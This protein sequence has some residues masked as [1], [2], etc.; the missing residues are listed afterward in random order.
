[1]VGFC[2]FQ[3]LY[4]QVCIILVNYLYFLRWYFFPSLPYKDTMSSSKEN[5]KVSGNIWAKISNEDD[6]CKQYINGIFVICGV[7]VEL[8]MRRQFY[9]CAFLIT[10]EANYTTRRNRIRFQRRLGLIKQ[11]SQELRSR[12]KIRS[13]LFP[14]LVAW[15]ESKM[16][17]RLMLNPYTSNIKDKAVKSLNLK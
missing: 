14:L 15:I 5:V 11:W 4:C 12:Q 9:S 2:P 6:T 10:K 16:I 7:C 3:D 17:V 13:S 1:M 8:K